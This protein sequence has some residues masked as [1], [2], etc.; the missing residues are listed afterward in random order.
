MSAD[1]ASKLPPW[2]CSTSLE[3]I[4]KHRLKLDPKTKLIYP[5]KPLELLHLRMGRIPPGLQSW[6]NKESLFP[7][8]I[9]PP[10]LQKQTY[11]NVLECFNQFKIEGLLIVP[12]MK[13]KAWY[14]HLV[15]QHGIPLLV[16]TTE[17]N[18]NS[19]IFRTLTK[20]HFQMAIFH[21]GV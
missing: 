8:I 13:Y 19:S 7:I 2:S 5:I 21:L 18:F 9:L 4:L 16:N 3:S 14:S 17:E 11:R 6:N 10:H 1:L 15:Q 20:F 12:G